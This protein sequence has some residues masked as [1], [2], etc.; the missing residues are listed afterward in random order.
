[1]EYTMHQSAR[2]A[3]PAMTAQRLEGL[4]RLT[5]V[6]YL[7]YGFSLF[8]GIPVVL[9]L[10]LNYV[11]LAET[12]GTLYDSHLRWT[13]RTFW[14]GL[15]WTVFAGAL[16]IAAAAAGFTMAPNDYVQQDYRRFAVVSGVI[17]FAVL[18]LVW[19]WTA[20]R[21]LRGILNWNEHRDMPG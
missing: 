9:A 16:L 4:R 15:F 2:P 3:R 12:P 6:V 17:G 18:G 5:L 20:Y 8:T 21:L 7:L 11:R 1:M 19:L 13:L 10:L 14:W